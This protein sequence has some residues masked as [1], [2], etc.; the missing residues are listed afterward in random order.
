MK[1]VIEYQIFK[2]GRIVPGTI[3]TRVADP[4]EVEPNMDPDPTSEKKLGP[5]PKLF[6]FPC[7]SRIVDIIMFFYNFGI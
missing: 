5:N 3:Y 7:K 6:F 1:Y 4:G 2:S